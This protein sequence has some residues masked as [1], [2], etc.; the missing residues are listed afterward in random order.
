[1][2]LS[3]LCF[4]IT[5]LF[6]FE[7]ALADSPAPV[8][9]GK[10]WAGK[11]PEEVGLDAKMLKELPGYVK[12]SGF[13]VR[14]GYQVF[15]W[16]RP[17][18]RRDVA[19]AAKPVYTHF[20]FK[21][22]EAGKI[23][24]VD[25]PVVEWWPAL[26]QLNPKLGFK[27][28]RMTWRHLAN[29]T[30][31]Y[32]VADPPG[33]AFDYNDWQ[34]AFFWDVLFQ[35][36]YGV[37][38]DNADQ[39]VLHPLL[40]NP[41]QCQDA[42]T[43]MAFGPGDRA[44]RM[45]ISPRDFARF[46][47]LYLRR[48]RWRDRQ[49]IPEAYA[50][51]VV[52][53]P[54]PNAIPRTAGRAA[55]MLP[56]KR[57]IGSRRIPDNQ[58]DHIGS[59]SWLWWVNGVD[60]QGRRHWPDVPHRAF[61]CFGH[62]GM[63]AMV[64]VPELDLIISWNDSKVQGRDM[65][66]HALGLLVK[67]VKSKPESRST[68]APALT[69]KPLPGQV[70]MDPEAPGRLK[71]AGG[72]PFFMCGPGDPEGFL[73][74]GTLNADGTRRGDQMALIKKLSGTGANCIYLM[75]VRSHGGDGDRTH[76][77]FL[78]NDPAKGI[79][80]KVLDQWAGW[81]QAMDDRGIVIYFF[82]YDD[83]C[84][85][86]R[87][88]DRVGKAESDFIRI[89]VTRFSRYKHLVWCIA[90]EYGEVLSAARVKGLARLVRRSDPH[91]HVIAVH[92][93]HGLDFSEF[94][95]DDA[96]RQFAVQYNVDSADALHQGMLKAQQAARGRYSLVMSEA[97]DFGVGEAAR[98]KCWACAMAGVSTMILG[99]DI[100]TTSVP[101]LKDCGRLVGF[102]ESIKELNSM[103][104]ADE[105]AHGDTQYVLAHPG[106]SYLAYSASAGKTL[107]LKAVKP[108]TYRLRWFDCVTGRS[109]TSAE[110]VMGDALFE[111][112]AGLGAEVVLYISA[113]Q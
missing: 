30:A 98:K 36:V 60:R 77:P 44:G 83:S 28:R 79:N 105:F 7:L 93:N 32:G 9:P 29:Q 104:P 49:L 92:K 39:R 91:G 85:V 67:A 111:K 66:N 24:D 54:L 102:M 78:R 74:R 109:K 27:D 55:E 3:C 18:R 84:R 73:Y 37:N 99:M 75:A 87:T 50:V 89:L 76:N 26:K 38:F 64:V 46:G 2:R 110:K 113:M 71:Y 35:K 69:P 13:V 47:L 59:Y 96:I 51:K 61:G 81:F 43:F 5:V 42:P 52:S 97:A 68:P 56:D 21:A 25:Q 6:I 45:G 53:E 70:I 12:G 15:Q 40:T 95:G 14:H 23:K 58:C 11:T 17:E 20:L 107:G 100:A 86:W 90:E 34:M 88:G 63:R 112:P 31:C 65:E 22:L 8:Y 62:G 57:S 108:G 41:L 19:S 94:A 80:D 103:V 72:G 10:T 33:T 106:S 16:G 82:F 48:G 4:L 101:D 1:M